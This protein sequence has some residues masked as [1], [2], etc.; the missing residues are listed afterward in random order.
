MLPHKKMNKTPNN[1]IF[2][3]Y[4]YIYIYVCVY[5]C[6]HVNVHIYV[7]EGKYVKV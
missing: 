3:K 5:I 1:S 4:I 7:K 2:V 6:I